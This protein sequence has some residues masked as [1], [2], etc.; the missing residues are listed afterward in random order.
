MNAKCG[1][2]SNIL[3][4]SPCGCIGP[5]AVIFKTQTNIVNIFFFLK[6]K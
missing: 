6:L 5:D 4:N 3:A 1:L 2:Q